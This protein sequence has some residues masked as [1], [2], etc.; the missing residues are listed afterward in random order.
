MV[1]PRLNALTI[2]IDGET[3]ITEREDVN[4]ASEASVWFERLAAG[5]RAYPNLISTVRMSW[6][7]Q[8][9]VLPSRASACAAR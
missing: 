2:L 7:S 4:P 6:L 8:R 1:A 3:G 9:S 5:H